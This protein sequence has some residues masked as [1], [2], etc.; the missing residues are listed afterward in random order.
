MAEKNLCPLFTLC[1]RCHMIT[2]L[3]ISNVK[4][5]SSYQCVYVYMCVC[6]WNYKLLTRSEFVR[7]SH[8][9]QCV[10]KFLCDNDEWDLT[11]LLLNTVWQ[12]LGVRAKRLTDTRRLWVQP[13][14]ASPWTPWHSSHISSW[15]YLDVRAR[16][17]VEQFPSCL[18]ARKEYTFPI[19]SCIFLPTPLNSITLKPMI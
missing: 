1:L 14:Q 12:R 17:T 19:K 15:L 10:S 3:C 9:T 8:A 13:V 5:V 7:I 16:N 2:C 4:H 11:L 6:L 18:F